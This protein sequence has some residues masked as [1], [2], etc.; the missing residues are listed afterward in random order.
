MGHTI[1]AMFIQDQD[2]VAYQADFAL[3][4]TK[5]SVN[6]IDNLFHF[7]RR[8]EEGE[9][10]RKKKPFQKYFYDW[11]CTKISLLNAV[12]S[13]RPSEGIFSPSQSNSWWSN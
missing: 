12:N 3:L 9:R 11:C 1:D 8:Y 4:L 5:E 13:V 2:S 7:E 6:S 10:E